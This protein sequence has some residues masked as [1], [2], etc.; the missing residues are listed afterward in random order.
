MVLQTRINAFVR[1]GKF[2]GQF[3]N[4]KEE[5]ILD[6]SKNNKFFEEMSNIMQ[7]AKIYNGWFTEENL[8]YTFT[9][10]SK[11]LTQPNLESWLSEY[12]IPTKNPK[13]IAVVMAGNIPLVGFHDFLCI[14]LSGHKALVKLSSNDNKLLPFLT[15]YLITQDPSIKESVRFTDDQL[16]D[17]DAVIATGSDNTAKYFEYYFRN[18][19]HIIRK[20][21]NAVAILTGKETKEELELLA[22]DVFKYYGLGCR[23]VAK[24][25]I[26]RNYDFK[27]FFEA[28]YSW[29][30]IVNELKYMNNYDYNKAIYLMSN[31]KTL[32][33]LD[34]NFL[35]LKEDQNLASPIGVLFY[36]YYDTITDVEK[37]ISQKQEEIQCVVSTEKL[38]VKTLNFG[39]TQ[40]PGLSDYADNVD[41][42]AFLQTL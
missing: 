21:R 34:N 22:E 19:P 25:Y 24:L 7:V 26:P 39:E 41:T 33:L 3:S 29:K 30:D 6:P 11:I 16:K 40:N 42:M 12:K 32:D 27:S 4:S 20:N 13:T 31:H 14:L 37:T 17:Y 10:W 23:N 35:L 15:D 5:S 36:S 9:S 8:R 38:S 28:M 1:L 2:L 18:K